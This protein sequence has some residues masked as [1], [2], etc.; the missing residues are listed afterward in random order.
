MIKA[1]MSI[2][3]VCVFCGAAE[4]SSPAFKK[5]TIDLGKKLEASGFELVYG[6]GH[7]GCLWEYWLTQF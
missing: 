5:H 7:V 3:R 1:V 4:G 2:K 6:G